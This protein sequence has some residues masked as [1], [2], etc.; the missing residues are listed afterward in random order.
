MLRHQLAGFQ[1]YV[2]T[3]T[4]SGVSPGFLNDVLKKTV[5]LPL[6]DATSG[7][8]AMLEVWKL[9]GG[10]AFSTAFADFIAKMCSNETYKFWDNFV[11]RDGSLYTAMR[12]GNWNLRFFM[13]LTVQLTLTDTSTHS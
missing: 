3:Q 9:L 8:S 6:L 5:D 4:L 11:H 1:Q 12:T 2:A 13:P 10:G 7:P